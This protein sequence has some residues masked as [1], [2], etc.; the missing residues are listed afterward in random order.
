MSPDDI[1][2][3]SLRPEARSWYLPGYWVR[4]QDSLSRMI[5]SLYVHKSTLSHLLFYT[6]PPTKQ[7]LPNASE[8]VSLLLIND[9]AVSRQDHSWYKEFHDAVTRWSGLG[10]VESLAAWCDISTEIQ[11]LIDRLPS[12]RFLEK[13][14]HLNEVG[15]IVKAVVT[16]MRSK[17]L[18]ASLMNLEPTAA[19]SIIK[20]LDNILDY[21]D[22][23]GRIDER[24]SISIRNTLQR[25]CRKYAY[26]PPS[27]QLPPDSIELLGEPIA[28]TNFGAVWRGLRTVGSSS[29]QVALKGVYYHS[30]EE[31][32][33]IRNQFCREAILWKQLCHRNIAPFLGVSSTSTVSFMLVSTWMENGDVAQYLSKH[34][35]IE[36][37][38][39]LVNIVD[40]LSYLH[41]QNV[42]HG[43]LKSA[44]ILV[45][46]SGLACLADFGLSTVI[47]NAD[48]VNITS[49]TTRKAGTTRWTAPELLD[50]ERFGLEHAFLTRETDVYALSMVMVEVRHPQTF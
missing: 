19:G 37:V 43:D 20:A 42:I 32:E 31:Y 29:V 2:G 16:I 14:Y 49:K 11:D 35:D 6:F 39:L 46:N 38:P 25:L 18:V 23:R 48:T 13:P 1:P 24:M 36:R 34:R 10:P 8:A 33:I 41:S 26:L 4:Q 28:K 30:T 17:D 5:K 7:D 21:T 9:K 40:G 12:R 15:G 47:Y 3:Y 45:D 44:N 50:P 22:K 27:C